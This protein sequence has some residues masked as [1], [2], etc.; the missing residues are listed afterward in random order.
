M[1]ILLHEDRLSRSRH[2]QELLKQFHQVALSLEVKH[3]KVYKKDFDAL[4]KSSFDI[5]NIEREKEVYLKLSGVHAP[6]LITRL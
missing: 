3:C 6:I 4:L 1:A 2:V 5:K